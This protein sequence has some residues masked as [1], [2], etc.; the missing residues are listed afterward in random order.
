MK[1]ENPSVCVTVNCSLEFCVQG[2]NKSNHSTQNPSIV[3]P[4]CDNIVHIYASSPPCMLHAL[5]LCK[6]YLKIFHGESRS[7]LPQLTTL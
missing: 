1:T 6:T 2:V 5:P 4:T 7:Q 3:T